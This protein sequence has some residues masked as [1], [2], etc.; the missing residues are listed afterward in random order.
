MV[1]IFSSYSVSENQSLLVMPPWRNWSLLTAIT[2]S[3]ALHF[4][5]L[6]A[7]FMKAIFRVTPLN[8]VE[9]KAVFYFSVPVLLVDEVLKF[10]TRNFIQPPV[11][12]VSGKLPFSIIYLSVFWMTSS[13]LTKQLNSEKVLNLSFMHND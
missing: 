4:L 12:T 6:Y 13:Q 7:P 9:W 8:W 11:D 1:F 5:I 3:M 2:T 10:V